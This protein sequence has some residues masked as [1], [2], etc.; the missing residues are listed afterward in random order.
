MNWIYDINF[1]NIFYTTKKK[2]TLFR[3]LDLMLKKKEKI[4]YFWKYI[5][6]MLQ[7]KKIFIQNQQK[8][9][10]TIFLWTVGLPYNLTKKWIWIQF[11][12]V[13]VLW[14]EQFT[15]MQ[16]IL[17]HFAFCIG[18]AKKKKKIISSKKNYVSFLILGLTYK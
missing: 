10:N 14:Y 3:A 8:K 12:V 5:R 11:L 7:V 17:S 2:L 13:E 15:Q 1:I 16:K 9:I 4:L 6:C 18:F